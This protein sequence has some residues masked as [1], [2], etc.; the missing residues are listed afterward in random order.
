MYN[1]LCRSEHN[2]CAGVLHCCPS[3]YYVVAVER[4]NYHVF[5]IS[6]TFFLLKKEKDVC[7]SFSSFELLV[8]LSE[9]S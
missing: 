3:Y 7:R 5:F 1:Y 4:I 9:D 6:I 8:R 2:I